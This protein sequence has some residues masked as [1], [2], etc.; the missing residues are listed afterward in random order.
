[1]RQSPA[2]PVSQASGSVARSTPPTTRAISVPV[3]TSGSAIRATRALIS[4]ASAAGRN[5]YRPDIAG[6]GVPAQE[7]LSRPSRSTSPASRAAAIGASTTASTSGLRR[8][9]AGMAA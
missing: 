7:H 1:M 3:S 8:Q 4:A 2:G 9:C 5:A 6:N